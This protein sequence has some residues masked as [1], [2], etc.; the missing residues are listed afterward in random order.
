MPPVG[1]E[2]AILAREQQQTYALG[3]DETG[4]GTLSIPDTNLFPIA[5][6]YTYL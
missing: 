3:R 6:I 2:T 5:D 1:S 4:V